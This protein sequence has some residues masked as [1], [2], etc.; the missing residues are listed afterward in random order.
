MSDIDFNGSNDLSALEIFTSRTLYRS[1]AYSPDITS[2]SFTP[3]FPNAGKNVPYTKNFW[4]VEHLFYGRV[5]PVFNVVEVNRNYLEALDGNSSGRVRVLGFVRDAFNDFRREYIKRAQ[6]GNKRGQ[7]PAIVDMNPKRGYI[8]PTS[9][10]KDYI[11]QTYYEFTNAYLNDN[12]VL[13][14]TNFD[15]F[16]RE[17]MEYLVARD[18]SGNSPITK[19]AFMVGN[20]M[21]P[22]ITGLCIEIDQKGH[23]ADNIKVENFIRD[24]DF[25]FYSELATK[26]GFLIDKNAPWRLVANLSSPEMLRYVATRLGKEVTVDDVFI[27][28]YKFSFLE[29]LE[30]MRSNLL[31]TYNSFVDA[32]PVIKKTYVKNGVIN[33]E[34]TTRTPVTRTEFDNLYN[35]DYWLNKYISAKNIETS[36]GYTPAE[37]NRI[38]K[39]ALDLYIKVDRFKSLSYINR[40]FKGYAHRAGSLFY[41]TQNSQAADKGKSASN[42]K[43]LSFAAKKTKTV[44]Y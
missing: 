10:Y 4:F 17:Y 41:V 18:K 5:D 23:D 25:K 39:N 27:N 44:L 19:S 20:R 22:L 30:N 2:P 40:K 1:Y 16:V 43:D 12:K 7:N 34:T 21:S 31:Q 13:R 24:P 14:V 9:A 8:N 15:S 6:F 38:A 28:Y 11:T 36:H 29:E 3:S 37:L 33:I 42:M 26:F 35:I 32:N